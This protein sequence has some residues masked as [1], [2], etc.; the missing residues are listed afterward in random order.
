MRAK[1]V[2]FMYGYICQKYHHGTPGVNNSVKLS[3]HVKMTK[4]MGSF[5]IP[6][7]LPPLSQGEEEE[8]EARAAADLNSAESVEDDSGTYTSSPEP[9]TS[10]AGASGSPDVKSTRTR[11]VRCCYRCLELFFGRETSRWVVTY[12]WSIHPRGAVYVL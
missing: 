7:R 8:E 10:A 1:H 11:Y 12:V 5:G 2:R 4:V 9:A 3:Q 6:F